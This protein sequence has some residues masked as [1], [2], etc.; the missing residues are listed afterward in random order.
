M[1]LVASNEEMQAAEAPQVAEFTYQYP[2]RGNTY[3]LTLPLKLP[4]EADLGE[5]AVRVVSAHGIPC[6]LEDHLCQ[7]LREFVRSATLEM[8]DQVAESRFFGGSVFEKVG[9]GVS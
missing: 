8:L 4:Y 1:A 3:R 5:L 9:C 2:S 6:H 7:Q